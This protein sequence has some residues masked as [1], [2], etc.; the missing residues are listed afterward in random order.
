VD[1]SVPVAENIASES[2]LAV[3]LGPVDISS[4]STSEMVFFLQESALTAE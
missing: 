4:G 2:Y 3:S 1:N